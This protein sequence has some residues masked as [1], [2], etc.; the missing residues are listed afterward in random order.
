MAITDHVA[1]LAHSSL[2]VP[3]VNRLNPAKPAS[4]YAQIAFPPSAGADL[5]AIAAA[6]APGGNFAGLEVGVKTNASLTKPIPGVPGDWFVVRSSTQYAPYVADGA[7]NQLDQGNP[8]S[9]SIIKTQFYAGKKVR[10]ALTAFAWTHP[11]TGRRGIS[12]NLQGIMASDDGER[13]NIGAGVVVNTFA[14]YADP[15]K[16]AGMTPIPG[17][18]ARA[19]GANAGNPFGGAQQTNTI[20]AQQQANPAGVAAGAAATQVS[21][22]A[23]PFAGGAAQGAQSANP[24][25]QGQAAN[26]ANPFAA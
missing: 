14:Q 17:A 1:I 6:A 21:A 18:N 26:T 19:A 11:Q 2:D 9:H 16:A 5:Q 10:A 23:N 24:F 8:A 7:G 20:G 13:L 4:F 22:G 25:A 15:S 3:R 12:F